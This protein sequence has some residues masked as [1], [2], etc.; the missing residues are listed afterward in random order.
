MGCYH[1][2]DPV[3]LDWEPVELSVSLILAPRFAITE[4]EFA[5][6]F[7]RYVLVSV[8]SKRKQIVLIPNRSS[9]GFNHVVI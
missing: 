2:D 5:A 1:W 9:K 7:G 8:S 3:F 6:L 4:G